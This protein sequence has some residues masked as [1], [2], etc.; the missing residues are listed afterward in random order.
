MGFVLAWA[1]FSL[2]SALHSC[3]QPAHRLSQ[4]A[5]LPL[6]NSSAC[7][8]YL[9]RL[10]THSLPDFCIHLSGRLRSGLDL[11]LFLA[12][13]VLAVI[14]FSLTSIPEPLLACLLASSP[15]HYCLLPPASPRSFPAIKPASPVP[16]LVCVCVWVCRA[17]HNKTI[18]ISWK[19]FLLFW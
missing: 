5:H 9:T 15:T 7:S 10:L 17:A 4:S 3:L 8:I 12:A 1:A 2:L 16:T 19:N 18:R 11:R 6:I 14:S 13:S